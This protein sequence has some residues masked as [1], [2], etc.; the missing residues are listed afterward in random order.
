MR[1]YLW[2]VAVGLLLAALAL[3]YHDVEGV[4]HSLGIGR[5]ALTRANGALT[6]GGLVQVAVGQF[7]RSES[8]AALAA[9]ASAFQDA[10]TNVYRLMPLLQLI[11]QVPG[12]AANVD[13]S[14]NLISLATDVS[15]AG[16]ELCQVLMPLAGLVATEARPD[17]PLSQQLLAALVASRP[18][19]EEARMRLARAELAL[20][21]LRLDEQD[22]ETRAAVQAVASR[23]PALRNTVDALLVLPDLLGAGGARTYLLLAQNRNELRPTGGY[24]GAAGIARVEGGRITLDTFGASE[25]FDLPSDRLVPPPAPMAQFLHA[26]YWQFGNANWW[27]DFPSSAEQMAYFYNQVRDEPLDGMIAFDQRALE[28]LLDQTGPVVVP[29][30]GE[31][32]SRSNLLELL[33]RYV[34]SQIGRLDERERKAFVGAT[35]AAL[36]QVL[37]ESPSERLPAY[38]H[39]LHQAIAEKHLLLYLGSQRAALLAAELGWDGHLYMGPG[40]Y[41]YAVSANLGPNYAD[42]Y[43]ERSA[44]YVV[45]LTAESPAARLTLEFAN[46]VTPAAA[47]D[48]VTPHYRNYLRVYVPWESALR[49]AGGYASEVTV[50]TE[51]GRTVFGGLVDVPPGERVTVVLDYALNPAVLAGGKYTLV[52]QKQPGLDP[53]PLSVEVR[54]LFTTASHRGWLHGDRQY[55]LDGGGL[56]EGTMPAAESAGI[57]C[58]TPKPAPQYLAPPVRFAIPRLAINALMTPLKVRPTGEMEVPAEGESVGWYEAGARP[59]YAGN[60]VVAAHVDWAGRPAVFWRLAELRPGDLIEVMDAA[61]GTHR[62]RV[63]WNWTARPE[64]VPV[65]SVL[66]PTHDKLL[67]AITCSGNFNPVTRDYSH[68]QI[69]RARLE[70]GS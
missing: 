37:L 3:A 17:Q 55:R 39:A 25:A 38:L 30:F 40:D 35:A 9:A 63:E 27:P 54:G 29:E 43:I 5:T 13:S 32:V 20:E 61:G 24:V 6:A 7:D 59:G 1:G 34:H 66:G 36:V 31:T 50:S 69:V 58:A 16:N 44:H 14:F 64:E 2:S 53:L 57:A 33:D 62:Y 65:A 42:R 60:F 45:D 41:V 56:E 51:C 67:T 19:L 70:E 52:V 68:R 10:A 15:V 26:S 28:L 46:H 18:G 12:G 4:R 23:L 49:S 48:W 22:P 11:E 8:C 21:R 47:A